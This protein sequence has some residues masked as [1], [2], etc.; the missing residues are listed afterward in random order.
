MGLAHARLCPSCATWVA[1]ERATWGGTFRRPR[2]LAHAGEIIIMASIRI[3]SVAD[4]VS[5]QFYAEVYTDDDTTPVLTSDPAF[6]SHD[7]LV[8]QVLGALRGHFPDHF[9]FREDPTIGV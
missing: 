5:G 1:C 4:S 3:E 8:Q 2:T 6:D 9:P 7:D